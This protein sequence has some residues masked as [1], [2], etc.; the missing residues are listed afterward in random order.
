[1]DAVHIIFLALS[2]KMLSILLVLAMVGGSV[3]SVLSGRKTVA[4]SDKDNFLKD[5]NPVMHEG[6]NNYINVTCWDGAS[7]LASI[8]MEYHKTNEGVYR[9][10]K[11]V[12]LLVQRRTGITVVYPTLNIKDSNNRD[13]KYSCDAVPDNKNRGTINLLFR[14]SYEHA[15][16]AGHYAETDYIEFCTPG[17][18]SW[19]AYIDS[20]CTQTSD[21]TAILKFRLVKA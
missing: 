4:P 5:I 9:V 6:V 13:I 17:G 10:K 8:E 11:P 7:Y 18:T 19:K 14:S 3:P 20:T 15:K 1:M 21:T 16:S 2:K 12:F